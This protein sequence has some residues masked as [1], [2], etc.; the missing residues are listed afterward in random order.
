[1]LLALPTT[2][3]LGQLMES[4]ATA[5][6]HVYD[7]GATLSGRVYVLGVSVQPVVINDATEIAVAGVSNDRVDSESTSR[8]I[9]HN[10]AQSR[11]AAP[12]VEVR[13]AYTSTLY[14]A[15]HMFVNMRLSVHEHCMCN[16]GNIRRV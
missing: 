3:S 11:S 10:T 13:T 2:T 1:M 4:R 9:D 7:V 12:A 5:V 14:L 6:V 8:R 16:L 15:S